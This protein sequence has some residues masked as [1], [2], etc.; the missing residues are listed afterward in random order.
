[1]TELEIQ[2]PAKINL[3]LRIVGRRADGLHDIET[4]FQRIDLCDELRLIPSNRDELVV[5]DSPWP[6]GPDEENLALR[7]LRLM[8]Q[9]IGGDHPSLC[10]ELTKRIPPGAG[11]G[12]GSS[13]AAAVL[14]GLNSLWALNLSPGKLSDLG[15]Q[16]G[17]DVPFF[18]SEA[19]CAIGR[20]IG[21]ILEP[22]AHSVQWP[23]ALI[24]PG[25]PSSTA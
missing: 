2:A 6:I 21:D 11:L 3:Y 12:G 8:R 16:L 10:I 4:V 14:R 25:F 20:G 9:E 17:A 7:A 13:D 1:M 24:Y 18:T 19:P 15:R 23:C 5:V 22:V